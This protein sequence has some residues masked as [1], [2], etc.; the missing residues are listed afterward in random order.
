M[1]VY[2]ASPSSE[3][4]GILVIFPELTSFSCSQ[5]GTTGV[6]G[7]LFSPVVLVDVDGLSVLVVLVDGFVVF[8]S[9]FS[10]A[11]QTVHFPSL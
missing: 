6:S 11:S 4:V 10:T 1:Q 7:V 5:G 2:S 3:H 9:L 8:P